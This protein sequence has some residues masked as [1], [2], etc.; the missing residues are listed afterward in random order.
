M[1]SRRAS[2]LSILCLASLSAAAG[3]HAQTSRAEEGLIQA[4]Q[5]GLD[6]QLSSLISADVD[7]DA[8]D[9]NGATALAW[10]VMR[11]N[12]SSA[13]KLL[14]AGANPNLTDANNVSPLSLAVEN[15]S[16]EL[17]RML[18][19]KGA[20]PNLARA[21]GETP[22]MTA[23][24]M[25]LPV[26]VKMLLHWK[27][28]VNARES[29][30]GQ[31][32]LMWSVGRPEIMRMLL[33]RG[34]DIKA[35]TRSWD[36]K[37]VI[38]TPITATLGVTGIPWNNDGTYA[39]KSGGLSAL[40][41][42]AQ[43]A[44]IE[45][46]RILLGEGADVNQASADGTTPLLASMYAWRLSEETAPAG[47]IGTFPR[48][49]GRSIVLGGD[50]EL[51]NLLLDRGAQ[52]DVAD[53][54]G[55][56]PLHAALIKLAIAGAAGRRL[57]CAE[58]QPALSPAETALGLATVKRML[59]MGADPNRATIYPTAGPIGR[60]RVNPAPPGSTPLHIAAQ[61]GNVELTKLLFAHGADPNRLRKD[62]LSPFAVAVQTDNLEIV[63]AMVAGGA[64]VKMIFH[65][66]QPIADPLESKSEPRRNQTVLHIAAAAGASNVIE[67]LVSAG[68]PLD[69]LNDH[70]ETAFRLADDQELFRWRAAIEGAGARQAI[71]T[72]ILTLAPDA[73][74]A[75]AAAQEAESAKPKPTPVR[76]TQTTDA[77][78]R[79][80]I[81]RGE[82]PEVGQQS[83]SA[84][85]PEP[86]SER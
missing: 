43:Q 29:E 15:G 33:A 46:V 10:A 35:A 18:L 72:T 28:D 53:A 67:Y 40:M 56:T 23:V 74:A 41:F 16:P 24:R 58:P 54:A 68:A 26:I 50:F 52:V 82:A 38:Y 30:F 57:P 21:N 77:F 81:G 34:A 14:K 64:E 2:V 65:P 31:T 11:G 9:A 32:A 49:R 59:A 51:A 12:T 69:A 73:A 62:G 17:V 61:V 36:V 84:Q 75:A 13:S 47:D 37:N 7:I 79:A 86:G 6:S 85:A 48:W 63:E 78:K 42:A 25:N 27:A 1:T 5:E 20:N 3:V 19:E 66:T 71:A 83:V 22:L 4:A 55:Y 70:N 60:V 39:A 76:S 45:S 80:M 44:D 8:V